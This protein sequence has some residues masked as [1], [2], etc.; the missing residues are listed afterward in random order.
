MII[1]TISKNSNG[2]I[3]V[4]TKSKYST[5]NALNIASTKLFDTIESITSY[6]N[7]NLNLAVTFEVE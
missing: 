3:N 1:F 7:N 5:F 4:K 2:T 6:F